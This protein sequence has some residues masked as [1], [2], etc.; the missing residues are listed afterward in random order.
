MR[1]VG[2]HCRCSLTATPWVAESCPGRPLRIAA[3]LGAHKGRPYVSYWRMSL[4]IVFIQPINASSFSSSQLRSVRHTKLL[5]LPARLKQASLA[6][7]PSA[8][9][10][11]YVERLTSLAP[12]E[13]LYNPSSELD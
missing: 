9:R 1:W 7:F 12:W 2:C 10:R 5:P 3:L 6:R 13:S 8:Y 11:H 4:T